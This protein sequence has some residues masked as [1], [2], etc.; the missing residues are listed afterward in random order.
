MVELDCGI[1]AGN[2]ELVSAAFGCDTL[3]PALLKPRPTINCLKEP[4]EDTVEAKA[5]VATAIK[6]SSTR[7]RAGLLFSLLVLASNNRQNERQKER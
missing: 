7:D 2:I 6:P 1:G 5:V 4:A 3:P